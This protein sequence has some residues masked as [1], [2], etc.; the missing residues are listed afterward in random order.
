MTKR[1]E[2]VIE[3]FVNPER[4]RNRDRS[5]GDG[6]MEKSMQFQI[7]PGHGVIVFLVRKVQVIE[8]SLENPAE[9]TIKW[10]RRFPSC[11]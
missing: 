4:I 1:V 6:H 7:P 3:R 5:G 9:D 11:W 2:S 10:A 8:V